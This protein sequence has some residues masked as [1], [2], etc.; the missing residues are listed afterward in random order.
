LDSSASN[1]FIPNS[2][3]QARPKE[4]KGEGKRGERKRVFWGEKG[5]KET[6][7]RLLLPVTPFLTHT[8]AAQL[9]E[10]KG[11]RKVIGGGKREGNGGNIRPFTHSFPYLMNRSAREGKSFSLGKEGEEN[12]GMIPPFL[13][14]TTAGRCR[15]REE[16]GKKSFVEEGEGGKR[17][18]KEMSPIRFPSILLCSFG[19]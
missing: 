14:S 16:R 4:E 1:S 5:E 12:G 13:C 9:K 7:N 10:G 3:Q 17:G 6:H 2:A 18:G 19:F 11:G 8:A 15:E